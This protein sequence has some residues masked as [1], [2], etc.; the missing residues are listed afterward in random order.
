MNKF[1]VYP[2]MDVTTVVLDPVKVGFGTINGGE[3]SPESAQELAEQ[4]KEHLVEV[5]PA[6]P[7]SCIDGRSCNECMDG[8]P[9]EPRPSVAGG[10]LVTAYAAAELT[11]WLGHDEG[12]NST[13]RLGRINKLLAAEG[14]KS[15]SHCDRGSVES[16][17]IDPATGKA[18]T[19][20]GAD[21]KF[22]EIIA[23]PYE[24]PAET[25]AIVQ[26]VMGEEFD[27]EM[28]KFE[29]KDTVAA[30]VEGWQP[31]DV[32]EALG[33]DTGNAIE[34]LEGKHEEVAVVFNFRDGTTVDRDSFVKDTGEQVFVVD[35]WYIE[36]LAKALA[37]GPDA[38]EQYKRLKHAMVAYQASTYLTLCDGSQRPI[39]VQ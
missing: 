27:Q 38:V 18:K 4:V 29:D 36:K 14:I 39:V 8:Q 35:V 2:V 21:D 34:I 31:T 7:S 32:I 16:N 22:T 1:E 19:G 3:L 17:F 5:D 30:R 15:G 33:A 24:H 28:V 26:V 12:S 11:G 20:C 37:T 6:S 25:F 10:A 13:Q 23:Q 9:P